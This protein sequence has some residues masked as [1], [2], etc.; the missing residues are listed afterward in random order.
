MPKE[1]KLMC[2]VNRGVGGG[3]RE[4]ATSTLLKEKRINKNKMKQEGKLCAGE[5]K[6]GRVD[7]DRIHPFYFIMTKRASTPGG[8]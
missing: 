6:V 7:R 1:G 3:E 2:V 4:T 5:K 8:I